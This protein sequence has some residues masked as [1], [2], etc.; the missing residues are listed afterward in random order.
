MLN[1]I[2]QV[3]SNQSTTQGEFLALSS[4][5]VYTTGEKNLGGQPFQLF[6]VFT[7]PWILPLEIESHVFFFC[8]RTLLHEMLW[9][10]NWKKD[11]KQASSLTFSE[12]YYFFFLSLLY[13][14]HI[15]EHKSASYINAFVS[16]MF[17][18]RRKKKVFFWRVSPDLLVWYSL[19]FVGNI[20][21]KHVACSTKKWWKNFY[22]RWIRLIYYLVWGM[23]KL[24]KNC[25]MVDV[26][27]FGKCD[28]NYYLVNSNYSILFFMCALNFCFL[29]I[30]SYI[31]SNQR[32]AI[33]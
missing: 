12:S 19:S 18:K 8:I 30:S 31:E 32:R 25:D 2:N 3:K 28:Y 4:G 20:N 29:I 21:L 9:A 10:K 1:K 23:K 22:S 13:K 24:K 27:F 33:V 15:L 26:S 17:S 14:L 7:K 5:F 16:F 6:H 11:E